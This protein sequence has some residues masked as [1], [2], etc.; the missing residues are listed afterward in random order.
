MTDTA[1]MQSRQ[2]SYW[3]GEGAAR[4]LANRARRADPARAAFI[5]RGLERADIRPGEQVVEIGCGAGEVAV[6]IAG[7][8]GPEGSLAAVGRLRADP[9]PGRG[10][11]GRLSQRPHPARRRLGP[12]LRARLG[13][14]AV[15]HLRRD[16]LRRSGRRLRQYAQGPEARR[17]LVFVCWRAQMTGAREAVLKRFPHLAR[18]P[19]EPGPL[20]FGRPGPRGRN[21]RPGRLSSGRVRGVG[22]P[23]ATSPTARGS[24]GRWKRRSA[25]ARSHA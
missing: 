17:R 10:E 22:R 15:L 18:D 1:Q 23:R 21:P 14:P 12:R 25:W 13:R 8:I 16:V 3:N 4:W 20:A 24:R 11:A 2:A 5:A 7:L 9:G 19:R 6:Q